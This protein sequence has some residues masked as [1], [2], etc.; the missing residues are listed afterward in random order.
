MIRCATLP[1]GTAITLESLC[2]AVD[3]DAKGHSDSKI[4]KGLKDWLT[5]A[6]DR[7]TQLLAAKAYIDRDKWL[8]LSSTEKAATPEPVAVEWSSV[9]HVF[10]AIQNEKCAYCERKLAALGRG[11]AAEHDLEHFRTKNPV[12]SW[13]AP[14]DIDFETGGAFKPGY[15][16]LAFHLLNYCTACPKCNTGFKSNYFPVA[17]TRMQAPDGPSPRGNRSEQP[18]LIYPLG[19]I[20]DD[21]EEVVRFRGLAALPPALDP[22]LPAKEQKNAHRNKRARVI[23]A[24]FGLNKREELLWGRA[25][26]LR[27]LEKSLRDIES[28]DPDRMS[29]GQAD[30][31]RLTDGFSEHTA[32]VRAMIR[33]YRND[34]NTA[35]LFFEAVRAY[36]DSKTPRN[37]YERAGNFEP[38]PPSTR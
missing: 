18:F 16:W 28:K 36:L 15:Y 24:F 9:K 38:A 7:T 19:A 34:P 10:M 6:D 4:R 26:R 5:K 12:K 8:K 31:R 32:C 21:P 23:I 17:G 35:Q 13:P 37:Y 1:D 2:A 29:H 33:I 3:S 27:E 22:L 11:G 30:I 20:D 25:E 14:S